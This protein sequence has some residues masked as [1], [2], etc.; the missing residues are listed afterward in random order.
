MPQNTLIVSN[1]KMNLNLISAKKLIEQI[2]DLTLPT[3]KK[4][5]N[6]IC[7]QF[8]LIPLIS[9]LIKGTEIILGSQDCHHEINGSFT[10]DSSIELIK[11]F[12]CKYVIIGHSERRNYHNELNNLIRK[13]ADLVRKF[14][15]CPIIC[16]GESF[17][18]RKE[19]NFLKVI[20]S[21][22]KECVEPKKDVIIAYEPI[23]AIGSGLTPKIGEILEIK[24]YICNYLKKEKEIKKI[25]F[26]YGGS[27]DS[28]NYF[29]IV[30]K[31]EINGALIGGASIKKY[32]INKI[33][34]K[35]Y[36]N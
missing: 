5:K 1:W 6:I 29:D 13:K 28:N 33:L 8:L 27:V 25:T 35:S 21:Q 11:S 31:T 18:E 20:S 32:E 15:L 23:W 36:F 10:G 34:T 14:G 19:N 24:N 7:P 2:K 26:L 12:D 17:Q 3:N 30:D 9:K 16:I 4:I 22:L